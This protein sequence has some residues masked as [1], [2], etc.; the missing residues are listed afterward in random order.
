MKE[1]HGYILICLASIIWGTLGIFGKLAFEFGIRPETLIALRLSISSLTIFIPVNFFKNELFKIQKKDSLKF[2]VL[3]IFATAF[4]RVTYFYAFD[5]TT[6][7][8]AAILIYT[9]P[10]FVIVYSSL[11]LKEK[12]IPSIVLAAILTFSGVLL[13]LKVY[14]VSWLSTS[15]F[16]VILGV[17]SSIL[18]AAYF[19]IIKSL[20]NH[21]TNWTLILYA[22]GIGA[23]TLTPIIFASFPEVFN[24]TQQLWLLILA[25]A[26]FPSLMAYLIY[27]YALKH[28]Q[29]SKGSILSVIEPLSTAIFA[30]TILS[31]AFEPLQIVGVALALTGVVLLLYRPRFKSKID[32]IQDQ[33]ELPAGS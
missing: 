20:R 29:A 22:D 23:L 16:G 30:A 1:T 9:Y 25:I 5:L 4:Q 19:L 28:V 3:G 15:P 10:L 27:S 12:I 24:Y 17:V 26:W 13:V 14:G 8:I 33:K 18:F 6:A 21:Y 7:A 32:K 31:E 2:L 11:F